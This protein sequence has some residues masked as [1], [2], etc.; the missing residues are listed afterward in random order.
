MHHFSLFNSQF[1][2]KSIEY[3]HETAGVQASE[4]CA[5]C[6]DHV[7]AHLSAELQ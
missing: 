3:M 5:G 1:Y 7:H 6:H 4:G 2:Y